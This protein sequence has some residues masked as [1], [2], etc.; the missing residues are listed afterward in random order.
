M[1]AP[2]LRSTSPADTGYDLARVS[3]PA[4]I[5]LRHGSQ[6]LPLRSTRI[7]GTM[8][9]PHLSAFKGRGMEFDETRPYQPG[10]DVRS[11]HWRIIART[12]KPHTKL[13]REE[14]ERSVL[15]WVDYRSP[16]W[17]ATRGVFKSVLAAR[18]AALLAWS[19]AGHGDRVGGLVFS[20]QGHHELRPRLGTKAVLHLIRRLAEPRG[21][22]AP[23]ERDP[24][25]S[26]RV[27]AASLGRLRHVSHP[28]SLVFLLSDFRD[29]GPQAEAHLAQLARHSDLLMLFVHDRLERELPTAG[30]FR[31]SDGRNSLTLDASDPRAREHHRAHYAGHEQHLRALCRRHRIYF[32]P[33]ATDVDLVPHLRTGLGL[34][35]P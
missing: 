30:R 6:S 29:F 1:A 19:A 18:T 23:P 22:Q 12:G 28:G 31:L 2:L 7:L 25:H 5:R 14:R 16:M 4:L 10:D 17:F 9:G 20:E 27:L 11:L 26:A 32:L 34:R 35:R 21:N 24:R 15:L 8:A 13:F 33:C 3:A